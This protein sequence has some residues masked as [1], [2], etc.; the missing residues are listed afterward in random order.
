MGGRDWIYLAQDKDRW[1]ALVN[2]VMN[3][4]VPQ[5]AGNFLSSSGSVIFPRRTLLNGVSK[6]VILT[7]TDLTCLH[8]VFTASTGCKTKHVF[9]HTRTLANFSSLSSLNQVMRR[10]ST[11]KSHTDMQSA[12]LSSPYVTQALRSIYGS[13][14][15][16]RPSSQQ[17]SVTTPCKQIPIHTIQNFG[18][19][20][21]ANLLLSR[22]HA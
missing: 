15:S 20:V 22:A 7:N 13:A 4:R 16:I 19:F 11:L 3:L 12:P 6:Q 2:A 14:I 1:R 18:E 5:N 17:V 8:T 21:V 9:S 10:T